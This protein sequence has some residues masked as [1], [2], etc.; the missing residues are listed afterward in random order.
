ELS[1]AAEREAA[2]RGHDRISLSVSA[3]NFAA[4]ALYDRLGYEDAGLEPEHVHG[5]IV[6]RG[7]PIE[8]DDT[9]LHL[10]KGLG[11]VGSA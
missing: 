3:G 6:L 7:T 4:Q 11:G 9:L 1:L 2:A 5:T 10:V 8:V